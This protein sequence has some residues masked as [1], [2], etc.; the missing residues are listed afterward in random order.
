MLNFNYRNATQYVYG[1]GEHQNTGRLL[2]PYTR[3]KVLLHYGG[4]SCVRSGLLAAV[5]KSLKEAGIE[6]AT[7]GGVKPN[8]SV[9]LVRTG[10][11]LC[12][13]EN[14]QLV[15]A[16]GGGSVID[17]AKGIAVGVP[18]SGDVWELYSH[19]GSVPEH[20]PLPVA[21]VLTLPA[22]GSENSPNSVLSDE[23]TGRKLGFKHMGLR[24][25]LS[26]VDPTLFLTLPRE[27]MA[28]GACDM[29]CHIFERYFTNTTGTDLTD[30]LA[31]ATMRTIMLESRR[32]N[33]DLQNVNAWG[34]LALCGTVA[35]NDLLG[36]GREQ[37]WACHALEH[38][39][40][41]VYDVPHGGGLAVVVPAYM[42]AVWPYNPGIFAQ[43]ATNVMG[44]TPHRDT[45]AVI[46]EGIARLQAWYR[47]LGLPQNMQELGIPANAD[48]GAMA[49]AACKVYGGGAAIPTLPG[50]HPLTAEEATAVYLAAV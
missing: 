47:E 15:L 23:A 22:A 7:L 48:F 50:V 34:Q 44:V 6:F 46:L 9:S 11:E 5:Q 36:L 4:S 20:A 16:V 38:E 30:A 31:E 1:P 8:P 28:Y 13:K 37:S 12:R 49:R 42:K 3:G 17:S 19:K 26:V 25:V 24:P 2:S 21:T 14:V 43:W 39:L 32:L 41:A 18:N 27:Q 40:S 33:A 10:I 35:H 29:M 45:E